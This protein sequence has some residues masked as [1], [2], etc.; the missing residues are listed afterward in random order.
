[1]SLQLAPEGLD[2]APED[3]L[4]TLDLIDAPFVSLRTWHT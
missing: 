1:M 4:P 2:L 3:L